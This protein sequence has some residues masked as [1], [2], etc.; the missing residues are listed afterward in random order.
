MTL[1]PDRRNEQACGV[2]P[3]GRPLIQLGDA[4]YSTGVLSI[5][6]RTS[7]IEK[8]MSQQLS[9]EKV[10]AFRLRQRDTG[11]GYAWA[12]LLPFVGLYYAVTRRTITPFLVDVLG[13]IAIM[14]VFLIPAV[15]IEDEE[16]SVMFSILGN[17]TAIAATP[18]LVKNGI[19]RARK[20]AH[21][22][23]HDAGYWSK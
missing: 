2:S 11:W 21:K 4:R 6:Q 15:A 20:A 17:L 19:D 22:S 3:G 23:L 12:H 14:I 8:L 10:N 9:Q 5:D 1:R 13:S 7:N 16:A 18:V